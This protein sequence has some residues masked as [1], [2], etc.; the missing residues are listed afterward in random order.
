MKQIFKIFKK[1][2]LALILIIGLLYAQ[3]MC[4]LALPDYTSKIVNV[5]IQQ[6]GIELPLYEAVTETKFN[7]ILTLVNQESKDKLLANY[8]LVTTDTTNEELKE[9]YPILNTENIYVLKSI[10]EV[11]MEELANIM[12]KPMVIL[13]NMSNMS[14][15]DRANL[16]TMLSVLPTLSLEEQEQVIN[17]INSKL[18]VYETSILEQMAVNEVINEYKTIGLDISK[19]QNNYILITGLKMLGISFL[20][21][22]ITAVTILISSKLA[23]NFGKDLREKVFAKVMDYSN[24]EM[25]EMETSS[26]ITR[27]TND[28]QQVQ[29]FI[30]MAT[31]MIFYAPIIGIGAFLK[32]SGNSMGWI[33]GLAIGLILLVIIVLFSIVLPKFQ[34]IQK[35]IDKL[36]LV[37]RETLTGLPVIRAFGTEKHEIERF[38]D[39]NTRLTNNYLFVNRVMTVMMPL[40]TFIMNGVS[41]LIIWVGASQ[42]DLGN[43]QV[44][45]LI[46]FITYTMQ[47]I[48]AFLMISILSII[49]PR[50]FISIKRIAEILNKK[51]TII[52]TLNPKEAIASKK[53]EVEFKNVSFR[54]PDADADVI[55]NIS[56]KAL[57]GKTTAFI[58]STG[59]GKSTL[60]NLI[61]RFYD[62]TEGEILVDG[63]NVR[64]LSL[65]DLRSKI[66]YVPQKGI[67]FSGDIK[68][69]IL[70][71]NVNLTDE[72]LKE[73]ARVSQSLDFIE[74]KEGGFAS[75]IAQGG[76]NVSGGQRQRLSIAR[77][78]ALNP[79][80]YIFD[81]SFS[82]LDYQTDLKLRQALNEYTK[83][84]TILIVAQR[85]STILKADQII[86][87][88]KGKI[89]GKGTH[90]ELLKSC[91]IYKEIA[92]SQ[93]K[94]EELK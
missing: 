8:E 13:A 48:M 51:P 56:F 71:G 85:I 22:V 9:E 65:K 67:L 70:F 66:G 38:D 14:E 54:Y 12:T 31:R 18:D 57:K 78:I 79:E 36:N 40:M 3:A 69:N 82:A 68:S 32:V 26:L 42:V 90:E 21:M 47:I 11:T 86:V 4:D 25:E 43:I 74:E 2:L 62:A 64:D 23:A 81:D 89:V 27:T 29:N 35:R 75:P 15:S 83:D 7:N 39:A 6:N 5:G 87:L 88:D 58:G 92:L 1:Y 77:A 60:I 34:T 17:E 72:E 30:V 41:L 73:V 24:Q 44:G 37:A 61:P 76:T 80:I 19:I 20:I 10:D 33:I 55:E 93:L 59:S 16:E 49:I 53:G 91:A 45:T 50:S 52:E 28:I 94:E 63:V 84:A 46:A